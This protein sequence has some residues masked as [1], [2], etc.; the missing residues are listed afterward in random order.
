MGLRLSYRA[1]SSTALIARGLDVPDTAWA[2]WCRA[3][4]DLAPAA[5]LTSQEAELPW[6]WFLYCIR[7][8]RHLQH[9]HAFQIEYDKEALARVQKYVAEA[10]E[11]EEARAGNRGEVITEAELLDRLANRGWDFA[12][13]RLTAEQARDALKM[14]SLANGANFSVPGAGKTTVAL[15]VH[16][17]GPTEAPLLVVAPKNAFVAWSEVL[18]DCL[19]PPLPVV[20]RLTGGT[21]AVRQALSHDPSY[22]IITYQQLVRARVDVSQFLSRRPVHVILDESHRIKAGDDSLMGNAALLVSPLA[23][24]RD[25]LSGTPLPNSVADLGPQFDFL[26]PAQN[27]GPVIRSSPSPKSVIGALYVR[28][29]KDQLRLPKVDVEWLPVEMSDPQRALYGLLVDDVLRQRRNLTSMTMPPGARAS[30]MRLLQA[31]IDPQAAVTAIL[32]D[33]TLADGRRDAFREVCRRVLEEDIPPRLARVEDLTRSL[34][35]DGRK[36]LI[37]APFVATIER[38]KADLA[39]LGAEAIHGGVET[40]DEADDT[41]REGIIRRFHLDPACRVLVANPAAGGEGISLHRVCHDAIYVGRTYNA[42][43]FLQSRD[44]IHRLG[45][46]EGTRTTMTFVESKAPGVLGSID[47]SVRRRLDTKVRTMAE[48]LE[49]DDLK[50]MSLES[51]TADP[52]LDD[53]LLREDLD[54][55]VGE[56][57]QHRNEG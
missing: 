56:L 44:R 8:L 51:A 32:R 52:T 6:F 24:R 15:A 31:A 49:D 17:A 28:T 57:T 55:L 4:R 34:A 16:L 23:V 37:W 22:S 21:R 10:R 5:R 53:G 46:P 29:T 7:L 35:A 54:D 42:A 36:V 43:H 48:V 12:R 26:W 45:I 38:L 30:V 19:I 2:E 11:V 47:M 33:E 40:G 39:D 13:R 1:A 14:L 9:Q 25:I 18:E 27:L 41:T 50:E 3:V 20:V